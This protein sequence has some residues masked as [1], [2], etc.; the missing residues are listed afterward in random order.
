MDMKLLKHGISALLASVLLLPMMASA[1]DWQHG[2]KLAFD[3][4]ATG[5]E[6]D[7][8]V[9]LLPVLVRLHS[10]NF[11]FSEAKPDGSDLRFFAADN[12]TPLAYHIEKFDYLFRFLISN[13]CFTT[14]EV[15][16]RHYT[17]KIFHLFQLVVPVYCI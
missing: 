9:S 12:K 8:D 1:D 11:N 7:Q 6:V 10:G 2:K 5:V 16:S 3:T 14:D 13:R 15:E 17:C 4:T